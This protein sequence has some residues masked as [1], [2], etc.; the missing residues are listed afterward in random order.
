MPRHRRRLARAVLPALLLISACGPGSSEGG[1]SR[2]SL[3]L[4]YFPN[5]THAAAVVGVEQGVITRAVGPAR[6]QPMLFPSGPAAVAA[7]LSGALDATY[8][9]AN[10]AVNAFIR[11][12]GQAVRIIAGATSGGAALVVRPDVTAP[13]DLEGKKVASPGLGNTQDVALRTW[14]AEHGLVTDPRGGG[15]VSITPQENA[16]TLETFRAGGIAGAWVPEPWATRLV[17]E[18][19]GRVLVDERSRWPEGRFVTTHLVVR[20]AY[21][22]AH[23]QEVSALLR[24][25]VD[26]TSFLNAHPEDAKRV[27][28]DAIGRLTGKPLPSKVLDAAW[29]N[30]SFTDDPVAS[31]LRTAASDAHRLGF[32][33]SAD[34][35][36]IYDLSLLNSVRREGGREE[37]AA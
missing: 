21:L 12:R 19:G 4:G 2:P 30:L 32:I 27:V 3:R 22:R 29:P 31:S 16:Q 14:L 13:A 37:V 8:I 18:G 34:I 9:G 25:H 36:G 35:T 28:S 20:T 23:P 6:L 11:S 17:V 24:G 1:S 7:L 15:D 33:P 5:L 26:A 10:P